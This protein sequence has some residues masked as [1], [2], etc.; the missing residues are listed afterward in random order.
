MSIIKQ[1]FHS[2]GRAEAN[3]RPPTVRR[4]DERTVTHDNCT[5]KLLNKQTFIPPAPLYLRTWRYTNAVIIIIIIKGFTLLHCRYCQEWWGKGWLVCTTGYK[6]NCV[7]VI[8]K[9]HY[10]VHSDSQTITKKLVTYLNNLLDKGR[11]RVCFVFQCS[12]ELV[13]AFNW[14]SNLGLIIHFSL[15]FFLLLYF[16]QWCSDNTVGQIL[17]ST[18]MFAHRQVTSHI[19]AWDT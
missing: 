11:F 15:C 6:G 14:Y 2:L 1:M 10:T 3:D 12:N 17:N 18:R 13:C 5:A 16:I 19:G 4:R 8:R 7:N 9:P